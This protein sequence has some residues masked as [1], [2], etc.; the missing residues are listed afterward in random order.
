MHG[1]RSVARLIIAGLILSAL[2]AITLARQSLSAP[3]KIHLVLPALLLKTGTTVQASTEINE[4]ILSQ[5]AGDKT[6]SAGD[7]VYVHLNISEDR[8][9]ENTF[10]LNYP[11]AVSQNR[12]TRIDKDTISLRGVVTD[13][14]EETVSI[15]YL[16]ENLPA[17]KALLDAVTLTKTKAE[18]ALDVNRRAVGH[19]Q[20]VIIKGQRYKIR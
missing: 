7:V 17:N 2:P 16:F 15:Q 1:G 14:G 6:M 12:P 10:R 19:V 20:S 3:T 8:A 18:I 4:L 5:L 9:S 13:R 11:Y